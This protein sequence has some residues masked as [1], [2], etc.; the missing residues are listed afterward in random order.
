M[1]LANEAIIAAAGSGKT[2]RILNG[3]LANPAAKSL[4]VTYTTENLREINSRLWTKAG[5]QPSNVTTMTWYEF[6][7]RHGVK[8]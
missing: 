8:P 6:L 4:I 7:V 1:A 5:G 3:A 2:E